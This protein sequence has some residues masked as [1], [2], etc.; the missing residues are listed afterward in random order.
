MCIV[1]ACGSA[2]L[3]Y[4]VLLLFMFQRIIYPPQTAMSRFLT[5][6]VM[7]NTPAVPG[8]VKRALNEFQE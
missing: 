6:S 4:S 7:R 3:W 5:L 1:D 8:Q 2:L